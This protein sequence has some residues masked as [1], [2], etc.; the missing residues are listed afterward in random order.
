MIIGFGVGLGGCS[1]SDESADSLSAIA[2]PVIAARHYQLDPEAAAMQVSIAGSEMDASKFQLLMRA[3]KNAGEFAQIRE[4]TDDDGR[5][6]FCG[7]FAKSSDRSEIYDLI[8][9]ID[10]DSESTKVSAV[11]KDRC[12]NSGV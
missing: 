9:S 5:T 8:R 12:E 1:D 11:S 6:V 2:A 3:L 7:E 4:K 10:T